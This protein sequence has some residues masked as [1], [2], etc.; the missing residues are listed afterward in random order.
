MVIVSFKLGITVQNVD[1]QPLTRYVMS[2]SMFNRIHECLKEAG[3]GDQV[4]SWSSFNSYER[5]YAGQDLN[6][7]RLSVYRE[8]G[9]GDNLM[10][11]GLIRWIRHHYPDAQIDVYGLKNGKQ[12]W[13][14]NLDATYYDNVPTFEAMQNS[15]YHLLFEGMIES[16]NEPEQLC[17]YD[18]FL[19]FSGFS[20]KHVP[21]E[22]KRPHIV[23]G[24]YD[25][26]CD[27][28]WCKVMPSGYVLWHWNPSGLLRMLPLS[29]SY[30]AIHKLAEKRDVVIC[31]HPEGR[32]ERPNFNHPRIHDY[33]GQTKAW[34]DVLPM[35][36][37]AEAVVCPDSSV[38]HATA[39]FEEIPIIGLWGSFDWRDRAKYYP[40]HVP[41]TGYAACPFAPCRAQKS[42]VPHWKCSSSPHYSG[43]D[44]I[45]CSAMKSI[46]PAAIVR[47]VE[48]Q[49]HLRNNFR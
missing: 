29:A 44:E 33:C 41:V 15:D 35:I 32:I 8:N 21:P 43:E 25:E 37:H 27:E 13:M 45:Y 47:E 11:T 7:R 16:D 30:E 22:F 4:L 49:V 3:K 46:D 42:D 6:R 48:R 23:W 2:D 34:R 9:F 5:R 10:V 40:T 26:N 20:Y 19:Q 18:S 12:A 31:G 14:H 36:R 38:L 24:P 28:Q 39:A 17:A 1:L